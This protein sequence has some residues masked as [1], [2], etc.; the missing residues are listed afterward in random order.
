MKEFAQHVVVLKDIKA[1][2]TP[3]FIDEFDKSISWNI[4]TN[5]GI[6]RFG[7]VLASDPDGGYSLLMTTRLTS[8]AIDDYVYIE[9]SIPI[10]SVKRYSVVAAVKAPSEYTQPV[11]W[12][13]LSLGSIGKRCRY[14]IRVNLRTAD[15]YYLDENG[16]WTLYTSPDWS[17]AYDVLR[18]ITFTVDDSNAEYVKLCVDRNEYDLS[19]IK[20]YTESVDY[21][22]EHFIRV[23]V[24][25]A[26]VATAGIELTEVGV[27]IT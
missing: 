24:I 5:T 14:G 18:R 16:S 13:E 20:C 15:I 9:R 10:V 1:E 17:F 12:L 8:P 7:R 11:L 22:F 27:Y 23:G 21:S 4:H 25:A 19:G 2:G 3:L 6:G 26:S